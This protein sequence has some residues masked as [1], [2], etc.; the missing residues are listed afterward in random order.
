MKAVTY[1][2]P[3]EVHVMDVAAPD[4]TASG[5]A[6]VK[7]D[8]TGICGS[9]LHIYHGRVRVELQRH[10]VSEWLWGAGSEHW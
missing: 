1:Q 5:D 9:D 7:V 2:A 8:A 10:P 6:I 4:L 3:G